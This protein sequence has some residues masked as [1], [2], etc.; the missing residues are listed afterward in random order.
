MSK[1]KPPVFHI[2]V[3]RH[4]HNGAVVLFKDHTDQASTVAAWHDMTLNHPATLAAG[5]CVIIGP[6]TTSYM[7]LRSRTVI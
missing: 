4:R 3:G 5:A 2:P 6:T 1:P 7:D